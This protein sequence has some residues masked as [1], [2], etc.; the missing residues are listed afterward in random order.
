MSLIENNGSNDFI[1]QSNF[2]VCLVD[3]ATKEEITKLYPKRSDGAYYLNKFENYIWDKYGLVFKGYCIQ[4]LK[5]EWPKCPEGFDLNFKTKGSGLYFNNY[6][7]GKINKNNCPEF[8]DGCK[9]LSEDRKGDKNPMAGKKSWNHGL[10]KD[11][12]SRLAEMGNRMTGKPVS[13]KAKEK[14][15]L[16]RKNSPLKARHTTKHSP[17]TVEKCRLK[18]AERWANGSFNKVTS[19]HLKMREFLSSL[20]LVEPFSEEYQVKY[21]SMDFAFPEHKIAIECQG[22]Y[23]HIDPRVYPNGPKTAMQRRNFGRDKAKRKVCCENEGWIIIE[24]WETEINDGS[25]K[26]DI[27][28]KLS[29]LNLI[30]S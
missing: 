30:K 21:F 15:R 29:E 2:W 20:D 24:A 1:P 7:R 3:G 17:E 14:M 8:A 4:Y 5:I 19:I 6:T 9:K 28:C 10:T 25:F 11:T 16:A 18:T 27:L 13:E 26:K 12:D 23:F 22:T